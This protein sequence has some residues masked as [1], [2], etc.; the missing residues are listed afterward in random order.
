MQNGF[1]CFTVLGPL[2]SCEPNEKT[3]ILFMCSN[4]YSQ[5]NTL[6][7][8][9]MDKTIMYYYLFGFAPR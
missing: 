1:W 5:D 8:I 7:F 9:C 6:T 3:K 2:V 4:N